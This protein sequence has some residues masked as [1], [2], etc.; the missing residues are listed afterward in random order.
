MKSIDS[1]YNLYE[2]RSTERALCADFPADAVLIRGIHLL[3][4]YLWARGMTSS[5][6]AVRV[7]N[8]AHYTA[9][10][11]LN[12][13]AKTQ[14]EYDQMIYDYVG[15]DRLLMMVTLIALPAMLQRIALPHARSYRSLMMEDRTEEYYEGV[16]MYEQWLEGTEVSYREE[17]FLID[18]MDEV[19]TL[20]I[21]NRNLQKKLTE[22]EKAERYIGYNVENMTINVNSGGTL[23]QHAETVQAG[24]EVKVEKAEH[25]KPVGEKEYVIPIPPEGKYNE[26]RL[27]I[28]ERKKYDADFKY[29]CDT[30]NRK[31]LCDYL[32]GIFG[33]MVDA[34][35]LGKNINRH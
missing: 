29:Y 8:A 30:H 28:D 17:D 14:A 5:I 6:S 7:M 27:Y 16:A 15:E 23:V 31:E 12:L 35:T 4:K 20:K 19:N 25:V 21:Q 13:P 33:W 34:H 24:G 1:T 2:K 10:Y 11:M 32:T 18:I 9:T 26:V 22:M 3:E